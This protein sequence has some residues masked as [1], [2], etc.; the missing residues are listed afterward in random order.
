MRSFK[1]S[2]DVDQVIIGH[3]SMRLIKSRRVRN[4]VRGMLSAAN[5][6]VVKS[7]MERMKWESS[8][9]DA[10]AAFRILNDSPLAHGL[11]MPSAFP[12]ELDDVARLPNFA[13]GP[14]EVEIAIQGDRLARASE[15]LVDAILLVAAIN[16]KILA[17]DSSSVAKLFTEAGKECGASLL[18]AT[19]AISYKQMTKARET[20][21]VFH[22]EFLSPFLTPRR[23]VLAASFEDSI[24]VDRD[25]LQVRRSFLGFA[26]ANRLDASDASIVVDQFSPLDLSRYG[27]AERLQAFGR[28][29][30][31]D[32][33]AY[34][35][36]LRA[37]LS[38]LGRADEVAKVDA[39]IPPK[40]RDTWECTFG[41]VDYQKLQHLIGGRGQFFERDFF[42][43]LPAWSEYPTLFD[44]RLKVEKAIG[45]R[46]DG[47]FPVLEPGA[48]HLADPRSNF[49][50]LLSHGEPQLKLERISPASSGAFHRTIALISSIESETLPPVA[51]DDLMVLL[52]QTLDVAN[53]LSKAELA[54]FLPQKRSDLLYEF[55]RAAVLNDSEAKDV[56]KHAVRRAFQRLVQDR[57]G[58]NVVRLLDYSDSDLGHVSTYIYQLCSERFLTEL[59]DLF[60]EADDVM[61]AQASI[62]EWQGSRKKDKDAVNRAKSHRLN[63]RL[64]KVRG[65]I[66]ETRI[67]VDPLRFQQWVQEKYGGDLRSFAPIADEIIADPDRNISLTDKVKVA[68]QPRL[69]LLSLLDACYVEFCT[70]KIYGVTSFIGRRIRHG[71]LHG[72]LVLEFQPELQRTIDELEGSAPRFAQFLRGWLSDFGKA[73]NDMAADQ[74]HVRSKEHPKGLIIAKVDESEKS[75]IAGVMLEA[76]AISMKD[77][78]QLLGTVALIQEYCWLL[79]EVD[80]Q[81]TRNAV[82]ALRRT[83]VINVDQP[84]FSDRPDLA[85][86][87]NEKIRSLNSSLNSRFQQVQ[88]WLTRPTNLIPSASIAL[89]F[90]TV[91]DEVQ[92]RYPDFKP[93]LN[94]KGPQDIDLLGHRFHFFYDALYI[95]VDNV[96]R[97]GKG[98]GV[99]E[100]KVHFWTPDEKH[101]Q[102]QVS[103]KSECKDLARDQVRIDAAMRADVGD[104]MVANEKSGIRKLRGLVEDVEE[105]VGFNHGY[106]GTSVVFEIDMRLTASGLKEVI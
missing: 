13:A 37:M 53:V 49:S 45:S 23:Q 11:V 88:A 72:H 69:R 32:T 44:Y 42:A 80:L 84:N 25:Y 57:F 52:D 83:F 65:A 7:T 27:L 95:L 6:E 8:P 19:K 58:G 41:T 79:F 29:G 74:M 54:K 96:A 60:V 35:F 101:I 98:H 91:L 75:T 30:V 82:E 71:T 62:L 59:Y 12:E 77:R 66:D 51:G 46:L 20:G 100:F 73:V 3:A 81:R 97:H 90:A 2:L 48:L 106:E 67:Y 28:W 103:V 104:A 87:V 61:E 15:R 55:L 89:L 47:R 43:H 4:L 70:N 1:L 31:L 85:R 63:L 10:A 68:V 99:L 22:S 14:L 92:Q 64:L 26:A 34:L 17:D 50:D 18:V 102:V 56:S 36:R 9:Q 38:G 94:F 76:V 40:V 21:S 86:K 16:E 78:G 24:D 39:I 105:I 93:Q 33:A 5:E